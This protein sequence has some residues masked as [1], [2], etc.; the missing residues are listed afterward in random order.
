MGSRVTAEQR[1]LTIVNDVRQFDF[2]DATPE[3]RIQLIAAHLND[4]M[5]AALAELEEWQ[6]IH[7]A[8]GMGD[9]ARDA[10]TMFAEEIRRL[11]ESRG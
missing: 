3:E 9:G 2:D 7:A 10:F 6:R 4:H 8:S 5:Y 1:A 11:R